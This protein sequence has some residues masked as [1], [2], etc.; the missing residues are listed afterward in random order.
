MLMPSSIVDFRVIIKVLEIPPDPSRSLEEA[1]VR[2]PS[3]PILIK[4]SSIM[5][6][7]ET[8]LDQWTVKQKR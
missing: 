8:V 4:I 3:F 5:W 2:L 6:F 1:Y 7:E